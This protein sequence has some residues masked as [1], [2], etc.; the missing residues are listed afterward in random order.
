MENNMI[1]QTLLNQKKNA[2]IV[3]LVHDFFNTELDTKEWIKSFQKLKELVDEKQ[4]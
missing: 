1:R 4:I 3:E 2:E